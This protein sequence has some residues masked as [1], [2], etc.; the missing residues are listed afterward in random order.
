MSRRQQ[1]FEFALQ[2]EIRIVHAVA[3]FEVVLQ[4]HLLDCAR[5]GQAI[6]LERGE[7]RREIVAIGDMPRESHAILEC[8]IHALAV[9]RHHRM[10]RI[11]EQHRAPVEMPAI[12]VQ[13]AQH[14]DRIA[15]P[16]RIEI[17]NQRQ[18]IGEVAREH[19][20]R[21]LR[22]RKRIETGRAVGRVRRQEQRHRERAF[23]IRQRDAHVATA[24]PD[25]Q[26]VRFDAEFAVGC[27]RYLQFLVAV[28]QRLEALAE[29]RHCIDRT[30]QRRPS[31]I[32]ADQHIEGVFARSAGAVAG[33]THCLRIE[34]HRIEFRVEMEACA[35]RFGGVEQQQIQSTAMHRP[36]DFAVILA[37][38]LQVGMAVEEMHHPPAHH[39]RLREYRLVQSRLTQR[40]QAAFGE[41][42]VDRTA[43]F[44]TDGARVGAFLEH[45]D[46]PSGAREQGGKERTGEAC[47]GDGDGLT[48]IRSQDFGSSCPRRRA[49]SDFASNDLFMEVIPVR[50][51]FFDESNLPC[52]IPF[53]D[54]LLSLDRTFHGFMQLIP[55]QL[56]R[57][58][59]IRE[60]IDQVFTVLPGSAD[61]V[62]CDSGI[63][64]AVAVAGKDVDGGLF[65]HST[66]KVTGF[67]PSRE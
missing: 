45:L 36:D 38:A 18:R 7:R 53:L 50:I 6:G 66:A 4:R 19:R 54:L 2:Q 56:C 39:H 28:A 5:V 11:A 29:I 10:G 14:A 27:R 24:R 60:P 12:Q 17:G 15:G 52:T 34:V 58:V 16:V 21:G 23:G 22:I 61:E 42:E 63:Q 30:T 40:M 13:R 59:P 9:E 44:V 49:S 41:R 57:I 47:A 51:G 43:A 32:G 3:H 67:P 1:A 8:A 64:G 55:N 48:G 25:M 65:D 46:R 35:G 33:E 26:R 62:A 31:T 20:T 37:V